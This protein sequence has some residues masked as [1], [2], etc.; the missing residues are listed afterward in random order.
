[1][2]RK[3]TQKKVKRIKKVDILQENE[4]NKQET[5]RNFKGLLLKLI[6]FLIIVT[7]V[8][9]FLFRNKSLFLVAL[10]NNEPVFRVTLEQRMMSR[11]GEETLD[12]L[13]G[14]VLI[15]QAARDN[16]IVVSQQEIDEKVAEIEK[17][18]GGRTTLEEALSQRGGTMK[19]LRWQIELQL[20]QEKLIAGETIVS[21]QEVEDYLQK[22]RE[23][24]PATDESSLRM[25][26]RRRLYAQKQV[27]A[28]RQYFSNL[29]QQAKIVK[30]L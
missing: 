18:L 23:S 13:I 20:I 5:S 14:E 8:G 6:I 16:N 4:V 21:D 2:A 17:I 12:E 30:F 24:L 7:G 25:E 28:M 1:M 11:Y 29:R 10:V 9:I 27:A 15:R 3:T 19:E 26:A 22:N